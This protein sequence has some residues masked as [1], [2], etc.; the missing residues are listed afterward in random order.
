MCDWTLRL[1]LK[2]RRGDWSELWEEAAAAGKKMQN[3]QRRTVADEKQRQAERLRKR[4]TELVSEGQYRRACTTL[5]SEG[6]WKLDNEIKK[7]LQDKHPQGEGWK[8]AEQVEGV[9][10][11][12]QMNEDEGEQEFRVT[13][14]ERQVEKALKSFPKGTASGG[15]GG[16]AQHWLDALDG[17]VGDGRKEMLKKIGQVC[18]ILANGEAPK[19]IAPW[20]AGAP[21]FP[22]KKKGNGIR[23]VAVGEVLRRLVA[24]M[25][26]Q[27]D[28]VKQTAETLFKEIGQLGVGIKGGAEI[29]VQAMRTWLSRKGRRGRGVLKLDFENAYNMVDRGEIGEQIAEHF[30]K[31]LPWFKFCYG[32]KGVLTCQG[33]RLPFDSCDGVQQGDPLGPLL[34]ALGILKMGRRLKAGLKESLPLWYLDDGS[35][36]GPG[37]ELVQAWELVRK[38]AEKIGMRLNVDKCEI[39]AWE[40]EEADWMDR[41]PKEVKRVKESGFELLGCPVGDKKYSEKCVRERVKKIKEVLDRLEILDDPQTELALVRSCIGFPRFGFTLRSAPGGH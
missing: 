5:R 1:L 28:K 2:A 16:R 39:W 40:G 32:V 22:L 10:E 34:F 35:I 29:V 21:L 18:E 8:K 9:A 17:T 41:F 37:D 20:M 27:D 12:S 4:V 14:S 11:E 13:F 36:V 31:L 30:P 25:L 15:S 6:V 23:P 7:Q 26:A 33:E 24:K 38:E 3:K 19:T